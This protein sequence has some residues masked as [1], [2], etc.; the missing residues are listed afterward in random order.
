MNASPWACGAAILSVI[1]GIIGAAALFRGKVEAGFLA[2]LAGGIL[3]HMTLTGGL[4]PQLTGLWTSN[5]VAKAITATHLDPRNGVTTGP[6]AVIGYAEPSLIFALGTGTE[7]DN[8]VDAADAVADGQPAIVEKKQDKAFEDAL[9]AEKV[10]AQPVGEVK[11]FDY[12][13]ADPSI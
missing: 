10:A 6:V 5:R 1:V 4:A 3:T 13:L 12:S 9:A 7:L 11:G 2:C 8:A